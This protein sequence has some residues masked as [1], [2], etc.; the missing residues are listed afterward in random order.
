MSKERKAIENKIAAKKSF[1]EELEDE[2]DVLLL[3]GEDDYYMEKIN[4]KE[5]L[6]T[7]TK[8]EIR[9]LTEVLEEADVNE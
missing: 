9:V 2:I 8:A 1:V 3:D 4:F 7:Q 5:H 6:I